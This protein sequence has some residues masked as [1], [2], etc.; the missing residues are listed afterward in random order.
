MNRSELDAYFLTTSTHTTKKCPGGIHCTTMEVYFYPNKEVEADFEFNLSVP[1][2]CLRRLQKSTEAKRGAAIC[3][4][5]NHSRYELKMKIPSNDPS[6]CSH[7]FSLGSATVMI[8][9]FSMTSPTTN[10]LNYEPGS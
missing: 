1:L 3:G 4:N 8:L 6:G 7:C 5:H 9:D 2:H 10:L